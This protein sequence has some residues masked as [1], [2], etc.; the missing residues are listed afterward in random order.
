MDNAS[1]NDTALDELV[2]RIPI[3]KA[4][5]RLRCFGHI[6]NLLFGKGSSR[7]QSDLQA[8][9]DSESYALWRQRGAISHLHNL[10]S[11][12]SRSPRRLRTFEAAQKVDAGP[13][14]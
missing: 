2:K 3:N 14:V 11:Y 6:A 4:R 9:N 1:N 7:F 12:I 5:T 10:V 13:L 8:A